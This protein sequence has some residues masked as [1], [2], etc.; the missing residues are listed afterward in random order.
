[1]I[2]KILLILF[3]VFIFME[4]PAQPCRE[5]VGYYASWKWY[6]RNKLVNPES[7]RYS[8][9]TIINYAFFKPEDDGSIVSGDAFADATLLLGK[10]ISINGK[11]Q[12]DVTTSLPYCAHRNGVKVVASIGGYTW[13]KPFSQIAA[14]KVKRKRFAECCALLVKKYNL[15]GIDIDWEFPGNLKQGGNSADKENFSLLLIEIRKALD[16]SSGQNH[17]LLTTAIGPAPEHLAMISW[18]DVVPVLDLI[19]IMTY[20]YHGAW[21][22]TT[23]HNAPLYKTSGNK[24]YNIDYT[25]SLL[26]NTWQV[27]ASK[28]TMGLA[29]YGRTA[30][31][32]A[33]PV[34]HGISNG[35][36]DKT[37]FNEERGTPSYYSILL[38]SKLYDS[39]YDEISKVPYLTGKNGLCSFVSYDNEQSIR[40]KAVYAV[41]KNL[42]G[43]VIW[44]VS[45]DYIETYPGSGVVS[46]TPLCAAIG[47]V[48]CRSVAAAANLLKY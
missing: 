1:M 24:A 10:E 32:P 21:E 28:I 17:L 36:A 18:K 43:V 23:N 5:V 45:G 16:A 39:S 25:I 11:G 30:T 35:S 42:G 8:N 33:A 46:Q 7:I 41:A 6:K 29:F 13:S 31:T 40:E 38:K 22:K 12:R 20:N 3:P 27:P 44:D 48:F 34:L 9:Y 19:H 2:F 37:T 14:D 26:L 47:D 15:D 4:A